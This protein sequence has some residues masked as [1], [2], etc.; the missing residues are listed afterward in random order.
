[1]PAAAP[2]IADPVAAKLAAIGGRIRAHRKRLGVSGTTAAEAAGMSRVT[3]YRIERGEPSVAMGAYLGAL[4]ALG[5]ELDVVDPSAKAVPPTRAVLP[6]AVRLADYPQLKRLA[7]QLHGVDEVTPLQ[8][9]GLYERNWRH[10]EVDA[11]EPHERA[12][13]AALTS[14]LGEGRLLV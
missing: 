14:Q 5:L 8:A 7:W 3:L 1:M 4:S 13:V 11:L 2:P 9:L 12:L 10:V 6:A